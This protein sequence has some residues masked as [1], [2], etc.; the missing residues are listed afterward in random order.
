MNRTVPG[1]GEY[2]LA[3]ESIQMK[4]IKNLMQHEAQYEKDRGAGNF[5]V[6][7]KKLAIGKPGN[8]QGEKKEK[9]L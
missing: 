5:N 9:H 4:Q 6:L 2:N 8:N 7:T 1:P 3:S